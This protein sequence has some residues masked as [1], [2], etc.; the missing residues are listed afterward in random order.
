MGDLK[1]Y[2]QRQRA[3]N[4]EP[5]LNS[6]PICQVSS[7]A[8]YLK[9]E[10]PIPFCSLSFQW[11]TG[12]RKRIIFAVV[13]VLLGRWRSNDA[14]CLPKKAYGPSLHTI[15]KTSE[16]DQD[17]QPFMVEQAPTAIS[18]ESRLR[19]KSTQYTRLALAVSPCSTTSCCRHCRCSINGAGSE[20]K[21]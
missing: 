13:V 19:D 16:K 11:L 1:V 21:K 9:A 10:L 12:K 3:Q 14:E 4:G 17:F 18:T 8:N 5:W 15:E 7:P 20:N 6:C 2:V